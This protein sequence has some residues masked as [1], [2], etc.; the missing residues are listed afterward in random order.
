MAV[1]YGPKV[2]DEERIATAM[3]SFGLTGIC[4]GKPAEA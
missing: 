3:R 4:K 1:F 2:I